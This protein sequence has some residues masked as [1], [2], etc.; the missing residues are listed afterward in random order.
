MTIIGIKIIFCLVYLHIFFTVKINGEIRN[1]VDTAL[2]TKTSQ[3]KLV[4]GEHNIP[5]NTRDSILSSLRDFHD[6]ISETFDLFKTAWRVESYLR[7][8]FNYIP[9]TTVKLGSGTFQYVS[10]KET[11]NKILQDKTFQRSRNLRHRAVGGGVDGFLL[12]DIEDGLL[13]KE[14]KFFQKNQ[15]ALR[16]TL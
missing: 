11:L 13:F 16:K 7:D 5:E 15:D 6:N 1:L 3:L 2:C 4:L 14:N 12:E 8:N 9:P 10:V